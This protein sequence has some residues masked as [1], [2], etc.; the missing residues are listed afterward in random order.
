VAGLGIE[1]EPIGL[2]LSVSILSTL[3]STALT[4]M[5]PKP[6]DQAPIETNELAFFEAL[7]RMDNRA[8]TLLYARVYQ[9]CM[10]YART[11]SGTIDDAQDHLQKVMELFL[12][13][14]RTNKYLYQ[15]S[16]KVSTYFIKVF[17]QSWLKHITRPTLKTNQLADEFDLI[18]T[19]QLNEMDINEL[20]K[21]QELVN[22]AYDQLRPNCQEIISFYYKDELPIAQLAQLMKLTPESARNQL[23]RCRQYF[24]DYYKGLGA[25]QS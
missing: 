10:N 16:A 20:A 8:F 4:I 7:N 24:R 19:D 23:Y 6:V 9:A 5:V 14:L 17:M 11:N 12:L 2:Y 15:P 21:N 13:K 25:Q 1:Y 3:T 22:Q 18:D